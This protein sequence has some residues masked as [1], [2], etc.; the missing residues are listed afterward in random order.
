MRRL[1]FALMVMCL[2]VA[3]ATN[4]YVD[5]TKVGGD[6]TG[7]DTTHAWLSLESFVESTGVAAGDTAKVH[8]THAETMDNQWD[9]D[10]S[11]TDTGGPIVVWADDG[12]VWPNAPAGN[13][14]ITHGAHKIYH[15][16]DNYWEWKGTHHYNYTENCF[17]VDDCV[18]WVCHDCLFEKAN[19]LYDYAI[20]LS[21]A[22]DPNGYIRIENCQF[23]GNSIGA[24]EVDNGSGIFDIDGCG[25]LLVRGCTFDGFQKA[26][27]LARYGATLFVEC[28]FGQ[29]EANTLDTYK[30][31]VHGFWR[32]INCDFNNYT[33]TDDSFVGAIFKSGMVY[34]NLD[35]S[36]RPYMFMDTETWDMQT[37]YTVVHAGGA[38]YSLEFDAFLKGTEGLSEWSPLSLLDYSVHADSAESRTYTLYARRDTLWSKPTASQLYLQ[39]EYMGASDSLHIV[40]STEQLWAADTWYGLSCATISPSHK[41]PVHVTLYV[42]HYDADGTLYFDPELVATGEDYNATFHWG[43]P[44]LAYHYTAPSGGQIIIIN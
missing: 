36:K 25:D 43:L 18:N 39:V 14:K 1:I 10:Q 6:N 24:D 40:T 26:V 8:P 44:D 27:F 5:H 11:G 3:M 9:P 21:D 19:A 35:G 38:P 4:Y 20:F 23:D 42:A 15:D 13:P 31:N 2:P 29:I 33:N 41:W 32:F 37:N 28:A 16:A 22:N 17:K 34:L 7:A 12:T 30:Q